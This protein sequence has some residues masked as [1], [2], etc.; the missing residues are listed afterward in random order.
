MT[1]VG[2]AMALN[3]FFQKGRIAGLFCI[4]KALV[5]SCHRFFAGILILGHFNKFDEASDER[6]VLRE[7]LP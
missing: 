4:L 6:P 7:T 3:R 1:T 2:I 5:E